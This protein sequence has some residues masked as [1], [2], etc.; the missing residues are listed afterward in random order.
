MHNGRRAHFHHLYFWACSP[1]RKSDALTRRGQGEKAHGGAL[2]GVWMA[3]RLGHFRHSVSALICA[4]YV[5]FAPG[6]RPGVSMATECGIDWQQIGGS[7][8]L[9]FSQPVTAPRR[10]VAVRCPPLAAPRA[11]RRCF[12][13]CQ[14][15]RRRAQ[16]VPASIPSEKSVKAVQ[17]SSDTGFEARALSGQAVALQSRRD[18]SAR[19][20]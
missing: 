4:R 16:I 12:P 14:A 20:S 10:L 8:A 13:A 9:T 7:E 18:T 5:G 15:S 19:L 17:I 3:L 6:L 11:S 2:D 1:L